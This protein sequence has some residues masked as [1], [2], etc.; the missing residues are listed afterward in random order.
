VPGARLPIRQPGLFA[1]TDTGAAAG[2]VTR[3]GEPA[4][5]RFGRPH[6]RLW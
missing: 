2:I 4:G 6:R 3:T 1:F 5:R